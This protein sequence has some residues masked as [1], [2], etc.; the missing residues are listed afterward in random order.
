MTRGFFLLLILGVAL[1]GAADEQVVVASATA[2]TLIRNDEGP[3]NVLDGDT[4][5]YYHSDASNQEQWLRLEFTEPQDVEKV[6]IIN[7]YA[8]IRLS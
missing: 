7:R 4:D 2:R 3:N 5:T 6:I 8:K 1:R